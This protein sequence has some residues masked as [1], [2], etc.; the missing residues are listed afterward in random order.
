MVLLKYK[1]RER[2]EEEVDGL[3]S[4]LYEGIDWVKTKK[5]QGGTSKNPGNNVRVSHLFNLYCQ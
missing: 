5:A 3:T 4:F 2:Y 1:E